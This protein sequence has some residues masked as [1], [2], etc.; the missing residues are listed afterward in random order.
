M[1]FRVYEKANSWC[2]A[3][4]LLILLIDWQKQL[5]IIS[6]PCCSWI[7]FIEKF[8]TVFVLITNYEDEYNK[9]K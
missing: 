6:V 3:C 4:I 1:S 5:Q 8:L 9:D 2:I 7:L